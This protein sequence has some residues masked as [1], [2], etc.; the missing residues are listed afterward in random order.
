MTLILTVRKVPINKT[1]RVAWHKHLKIAKKR[2][3]K[4]AAAAPQRPPAQTRR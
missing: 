1:K 3:D 2:R 4:A